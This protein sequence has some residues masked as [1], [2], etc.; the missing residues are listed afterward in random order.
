MGVG[1]RH[2]AGG[3]LGFDWALFRQVVSKG[4]TLLAW[5]I[6]SSTDPMSGFFCTTKE[7][8]DRGRPTINPIGFKIGL[9]IMVRCRCR[10][11]ADVGIKFMERAAGE[12]KLSA[13]QYKFYV[14]QL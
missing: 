12:S 4:A 13:S 6:A 5:P 2:V 14:M 8:L 1:S 11:V 7:V 3:G 10:T 9:E